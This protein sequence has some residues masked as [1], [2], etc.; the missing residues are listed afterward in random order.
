MNK[1]FGPKLRRLP[2]KQLLA[3]MKQALLDGRPYKFRLGQTVKQKAEAAVERRKIQEQIDEISAASNQQMVNKPNQVPLTTY[4]AVDN[5]VPGPA[6]PKSNV[7]Y[8][9]ALV[10]HLA[11]EMVTSENYHSDLPSIVLKE[12]I[13]EAL[14]KIFTSNISQD[15]M[16]IHP[17]VRYNTDDIL[18]QVKVLIKQVEKV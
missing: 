17:L 7:S 3:I 4:M 14:S 9:H 18:E 13:E 16:R 8:S 5:I 10:T 15:L 11:H 6:R 1:I 12:V 2:T